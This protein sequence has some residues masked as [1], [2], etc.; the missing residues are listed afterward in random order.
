MNSPADESADAW[1]A[2]N[3]FLSSKV[4]ISAFV[5]AE[6]SE[7]TRWGMTGADKLIYNAKLIAADAFER[8]LW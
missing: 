1:H 2:M 7:D 8:E 5:E 4:C 6:S 3:F